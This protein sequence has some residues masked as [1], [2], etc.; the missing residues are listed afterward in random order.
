MTDTAT[1]LRA[2][3]TGKTVPK[4]RTIFEYLDDKRVQNGLAAVAGKYLSAERLLRLCINA[5]KKTPLLLRC[6][7]QTVLGAVMT[8]AALGLEPNTV[9]QQ[10]FLIPYKKRTKQGNE[11]VDVY[12]CQFQIGARGFVTLAY[13][14][15]LIVQLQAEAIHEGDQFKHR[16]G[17]QAMCEFEK[18]LRERGDL[19]G[20]FS[21]V[22]MERAEMTCVLPLEELLKIRARSETWRALTNNV[23]NARDEAD[24]RR[25]EGKLAETPWVMWVDDMAA[26]SAIKKHAKQL[27][28]ASSDA[29]VT[30]A[31]LD[32]RGDA[33]SLDLR[34]MTDVDTVREVVGEGVEPPAL[35]HQPPDTSFTEAFGATA[36]QAEKVPAQTDGQQPPNTPNPPAQAEAASPS[37]PG[38]KSSAKNPKPDAPGVTLESLRA[39]LDAAKDADAAALVLDKARA[40]P[41]PERV[42]LADQFRNRWNA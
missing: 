11:W 4:P 19:I 39:E 21:Y 1:A 27:P 10:A 15:P 13:R 38:R 33:G 28:I 34:A 30:A 5:V 8:T 36:R 12:E 22:R 7:P 23:E 41:E 25:A 20:A 24:K 16:L 29:L 35:E 6:D 14:S 3:A 26:K 17:S 32:N 18:A 2:A 9:Q 42:A 31:E 37:G 40:L